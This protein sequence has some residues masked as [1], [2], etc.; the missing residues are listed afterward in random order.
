MIAAVAAAV[1]ISKC[2]GCCCGEH[3]LNFVAL[4]ERNR[5]PARSPSHRRHLDERRVVLNNKSA[6]AHRDANARARDEEWKS[7]QTSGRPTNAE[8]I[9]LVAAR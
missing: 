4:R 8:R 5:L 7:K 9:N 3:N 2:C 6:R 1:A